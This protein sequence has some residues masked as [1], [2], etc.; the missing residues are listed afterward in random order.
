MDSVLRVGYGLEIEKLVAKLLGDVPANNSS[1]AFEDYMR[2]K[3]AL[4]QAAGTRLMAPDML[5][6][7]CLGCFQIR[8][9]RGLEGGWC[10]CGSTQISNTVG[11]MNTEQIE[12]IVKDGY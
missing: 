6:Y 12:K 4:L 8:S 10:K 1:D 5:F 11:K 3:S 9:N 2:T 7:R